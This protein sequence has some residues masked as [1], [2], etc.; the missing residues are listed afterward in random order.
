MSY[1]DLRRSVTGVY[2]YPVALLRTGQPIL[3]A[4]VGLTAYR[5]PQP[6]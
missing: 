2:P 4:M 5:A 3:V 1:P 6:S